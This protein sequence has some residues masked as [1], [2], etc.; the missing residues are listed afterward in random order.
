MKKKNRKGGINMEKYTFNI[1]GC[2]CDSGC[3]CDVDGDS[4]EAWHKVWG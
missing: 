3:D 1:N 4:D 2:D